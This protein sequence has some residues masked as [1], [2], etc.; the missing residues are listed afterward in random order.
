MSTKTVNVPNIGCNGC[1]STIK[2]E[3]SEIAG[4]AK[5]DGVVESKSI[6]VEWGDPADWNG[7]VAKMEEI[8]YAPEA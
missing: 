1:V 3:L 6:T 5:V 2:S 8:G 4:V 7:I